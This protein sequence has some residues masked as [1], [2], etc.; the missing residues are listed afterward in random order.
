MYKKI[1][2][3]NHDAY[4][5]VVTVAVDVDVVAVAVDVVAVPRE[6]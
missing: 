2:H 3:S 5:I 6:S 1:A 4:I